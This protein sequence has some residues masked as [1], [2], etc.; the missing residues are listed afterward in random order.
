MKSHNTNTPQTSDTVVI[1]GGGQAGLQAAASLRSDG[2]AGHVTIVAE[3]IEHPYHRPPLSKEYLQGT[4]GG[5]L[6]LLRTP[7]F[8]AERDIT[9]LT[10]TAAE[11]IDR[12]SKQ[13]HL[14]DGTILDY[15]HLILATGARNREL[16]TEGINLPG[17][18][19]LRTAADAQQLGQALQTA[20]NVV[21]VGAG[22]IGLEFATVALERGCQVTVLEFAPRP[23]GRALT[24]V[25]GDWFAQ[26]HQDLGVN[27]RLNEGIAAFEAND[28]GQVGF[29][30]STTG[31]R[32][33][34]DLVVVGVG[35]QPNDELAAAAGLKTNNGI[36]VDGHL[37][38]SD[39]NIYAI[40]DCANFPCE[41]FGGPFRL[42]S[43]QNAT[44]HGRHVAREILRASKTPYKDLPWFWST[45]GPFRLQMAG[46]VQPDDETLILGD[47][48]NAKFSVL[49][50]RNSVL[51]A[52]ESVN[53][54]ADHMAARKILTAGIQI[55]RQEA[56]TEDFTLR[57]A[58]K[59]R[60]QP[61]SA[62]AQ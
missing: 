59:Q 54:P 52:V 37:R 30:V 35:V 41:H 5:S 18:Y 3:E 10:G 29:A 32:Y 43:V 24:P 23:M 20:K 21:V 53:M 31:E 55:T 11:S 13:V 46:I 58:F 39:P 2:F 42:E 40:G 44:D 28:K 49:C 17:I 7:E 27:L 12:Q 33:P 22:F 47:Q 19:G 34:A 6:Q 8:Y 36:V 26:A 56:L 50:F 48:A 1:I 57:A 9:L 15:T 51:A 14:A 4:E 61:V 16:P 25:L 38:T 62:T 45:Q 60:S